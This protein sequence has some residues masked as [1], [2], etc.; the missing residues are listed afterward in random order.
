MQPNFQYV[1]VPANLNP[2]SVYTIDIAVFTNIVDAQRF[3]AAQTIKNS[4]QYIICASEKYTE[5]AAD[6]TTTALDE[7]AKDYV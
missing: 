5:V 3:A 6:W 7:I 4:K 1:V 2:K